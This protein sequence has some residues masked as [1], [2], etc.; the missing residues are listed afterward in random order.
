MLQQLSAILYA[1]SLLGTPA[2]APARAVLPAS[3]TVTIHRHVEEVRLTFSVDSGTRPMKNLPASAF[4]VYDDE[5]TVAPTSFSA[6]ADLP[7]RIGLLVD[8]SDS[9]R[10][11]FAAEQQAAQRFLQSVLRPDVDDIFLLAFTDRLSFLQG[12]IRDENTFAAA[13]NA[14]TPG[15]QTALYDAVQAA[16]TFEMM[17]AAESRSVRK[18]LIVLSDGEDNY[19]RHS[20]ADAVAAAQKSDVCI[21]ALTVHSSRSYSRGD[22]VL[23]A[24]AD[25]TGGRAFILPNLRHLDSVFL[26]I[27][28]ELR[29]EYM[30][31]F[32]PPEPGHCGYHS[33]SLRTRDQSLHVRARRGYFACDL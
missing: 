8:R 23:A 24:L 7:L 2:A 13:V 20:L 32:R 1:G 17:T 10:K 12:K 31:S 27:E 9:V 15:G 26:Q 11:E 29:S 33:L 21:Y 5:Q 3:P 19:S 18:V 30:L 25:A 22:G 6:D 16:A 28:D 4:A 14:L